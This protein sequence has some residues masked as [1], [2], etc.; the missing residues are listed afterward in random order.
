MVSCKYDDKETV[1]LIEEELIKILKIN[2][3]IQ[4]TTF[5]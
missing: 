2:L 1:K 5:Q 4:L 3:D